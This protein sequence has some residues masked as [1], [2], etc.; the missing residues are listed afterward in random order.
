MTRK[1]MFPF[2]H[3]SNGYQIWRNVSKIPKLFVNTTSLHKNQQKYLPERMI[4]SSTP[5]VSSTTVTFLR[6]TSPTA[7]S[8]Q[9]SSTKLLSRNTRDQITQDLDNILPDFSDENVRLKKAK[10]SLVASMSFLFW[11]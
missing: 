10:S 4:D 5:D 7:K 9:F 11:L 3:Q 2:K 1:Q 8:I 6:K